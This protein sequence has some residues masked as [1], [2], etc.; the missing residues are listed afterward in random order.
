LQA[1]PFLQAALKGGKVHYM[2]LNDLDK[3]D[4]RRYNLRKSLLG[5]VMSGLIFML[6]K[7][8]QIQFSFAYWFSPPA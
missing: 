6:S 3:Q 2:Q 4:D 8:T 1:E 5:K 7:Q